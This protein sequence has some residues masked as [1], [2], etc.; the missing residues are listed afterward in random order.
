M[1]DD[2]DDINMRMDSHMEQNSESLNN[3]N[4]IH[5]PTEFPSHPLSVYDREAQELYD[6]VCFTQSFSFK[7]HSFVIYYFLF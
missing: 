1:M 7:F 2:D 4:I 3:N 5:H 6:A